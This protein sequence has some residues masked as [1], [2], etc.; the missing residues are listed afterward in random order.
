MGT[1]MLSVLS[2]HWRYAHI[3]DCIRPALHLPW[4]L[5]WDTTVKP[6]YGN[7]QGA[8]IGYNPQKPGRPSHVYHFI[9]NTYVI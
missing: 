9:A 5:D 2:G 1:I 6:L 3:I 4:I 7:Q 8:K